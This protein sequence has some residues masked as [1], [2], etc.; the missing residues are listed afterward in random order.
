MTILI[1]LNSYV[2]RRK[3]SLLAT[4]SKDM[5]NVDMVRLHRSG[6]LGDMEYQIEAFSY[7][8]IKELGKIAVVQSPKKK[9][10]GHRFRNQRR[11]CHDVRIQQTW[12]LCSEQSLRKSHRA[13][14]GHHSHHGR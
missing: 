6:H 12:L 4:E 5:Q 8:K 13:V 7:L 1:V 3:L 10:N 11:S 9:L 2:W 14:P